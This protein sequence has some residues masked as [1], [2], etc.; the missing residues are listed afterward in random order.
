MKSG[1]YQKRFYRDL[2]R[3]R[4]LHL[5]HIMDRESDLQVLTNKRLDRHFLE[6]K[7]KTYR[8]E[9]ENYINRDHMFL[10][11]LKPI[12]VELHAPLI[13]KE[14]ALQA[15]KA[16]VGPMAAVAGSIAEFLGR[17]LL[18]NGYKD[19]IV[20]NGGDIFLKTRKTRNIGIYAGRSK[21]WNKLKL[22]I[23]PS[24]T[25]LG[26]CTSS[27]TIGHSLSFGIADCVIALSKHAG[28]ADAVATAA[29]NQVQSKDDLQKA[30]DFAKS[31]RGITGVAV[32]LKNNLVS[33]GKI[34]FTS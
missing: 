10:V 6:Q 26:I 34:E 15:R 23:K 21:L 3:D 2:V 27:G 17:D 4:D 14:M 31:V 33:W 19:V 7:L 18:K 25:P 5:T 30:I 29:A 11:S 24:E 20:E 28:L 1:R 13:V 9:I 8:L 16:N 32:I 22:K 12:E